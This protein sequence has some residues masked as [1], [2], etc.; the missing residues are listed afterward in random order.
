MDPVLSRGSA[1]MAQSVRAEV[2][3]KTAHYIYVKLI[4]IGE[5]KKACL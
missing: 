2:K 1:S 4:Q 3:T 5:V